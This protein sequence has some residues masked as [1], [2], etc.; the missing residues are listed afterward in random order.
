MVFYWQSSWDSEDWD[1]RY[2]H[3]TGEEESFA[4]VRIET[5]PSPEKKSRRPDWS[6]SLHKQDKAL[7]AIMDEV[8]QTSEARSY[9]L[10]SIG[11]RTALDRITEMLGIDP[12]LGFEKKVQALFDGGWVGDTERQTLDVVADAG[13]AAAHRGW[14]PDEEAFRVLLTTL[15]HFIQRAILTGKKALD[16]A[17]QVPKRSERKR[18]TG[19]R[20]SQ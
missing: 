19:V 5:H 13:S 10:A 16:V 12:E 2:N 14:T 9:I 1:F 4:T 11:L 7:S 3:A 6:W 18:K 8:Y 17:P 20:P 15:E